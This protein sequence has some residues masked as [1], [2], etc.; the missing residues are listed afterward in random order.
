MAGNRPGRVEQATGEHQHSRARHPPAAQRRR[1][2][3]APRTPCRHEP[4]ERY[5]QAATPASSLNQADTVSG[6]MCWAGL[7]D[8]RWALLRR[9]PT[10]RFPWH[11]IRE[12]PP[13]SA[14]AVL[15]SEPARTR[16]GSG[17]D[18]VR[19]PLRGDRSAAGRGAG[20]EASGHA[21]RPGCVRCDAGI[22]HQRLDGIGSVRAGLG[23]R[24]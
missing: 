20:F 7:A 3:P 14:Y 13:M 19:R 22:G 6:D 17:A 5:D 23:A 15:L 8:R 1:P 18:T 21:A 11:T 12:V 10:T 4:S 9:T 2:S 24:Q 16:R